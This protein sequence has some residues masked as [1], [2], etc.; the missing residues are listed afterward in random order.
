MASGGVSLGRFRGDPRSRKRFVPEVSPWPYVQ[1]W[2]SVLC[3]A[4]RGPRSWIAGLGRQAA[5]CDGAAEVG[6]GFG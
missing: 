5:R 6:L 1:R 3:H 4:V 2:P